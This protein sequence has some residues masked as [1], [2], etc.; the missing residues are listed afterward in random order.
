M[1]MLLLP[2]AVNQLNHELRTSLTTILG[3]V[4]LLDKEVLIFN[5]KLYLQDLKKYVQDLLSFVDRLPG[6]VEEVS[7]T[8]GAPDEVKTTPLN[9][10]P[11][12]VLL[13][14]DTPIIQIV[15]KR[16]LE[17]LGYEVELVCS[18]EKALYKI[19]TTTYDVIL[20]D[21]GLP[22]MSGI[23]AAVEIRRQEQHG[24]NVPIIVLTAYSDKK[25]Y[26]DCV[27]AG[28]NDIVTK[29][30]SQEELQSL[31]AHYTNK[32]MTVSI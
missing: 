1:K 22:G 5:R 17:N 29:P 28:I 24:Q 2:N 11:F 19:N 15:H 30:V 31:M 13:V 23:D 20:M 32:Q 8:Q 25:M 18:A 4:M 16:M 3:T 27:N 26:Q 9:T 6:L 21:I 12:K 7:L 10:Y 14:E